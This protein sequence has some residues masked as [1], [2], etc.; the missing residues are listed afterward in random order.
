L[1]RSPSRPFR[2]FSRCIIFF[3]PQPEGDQMPNEKKVIRKLR[4]ILSADVK[5]YSILMADDEAFTIK[6][7]KE[8]RNI[9]T[10]Q[11]E[12]YEGR[13]VDAPGDNLLAEFSSAVDAVECAV[14]IQKRLKRENDQFAE[15]KKL[16]Y[17]IGVNIGD[18]V[19]DG[20]HIYG[21]GVNVAARIE[22]LAEPGGV[23]ISRNTYDHIKDKLNFGYE[24]LG[25]HEVKNIKDPVRVYKVL[26]GPGDAG[27]L[28]GEKSHRYRKKWPGLAVASVAIL[29]GIIA[30]Q[31]YYEKSPP[32][33]AAS[34]ENMAFP[35]PDKPSIAVLPF[36]NISN[37]PKQEYFSDGITE[38][39]ITA[40]SKTPKILVIARNSTFSYKG[41]ATKIKQVA[42]ELGVQYVLEGSVRKEK[43]RV[44]IIAHLIDVLTGHHLWAERYDRNLN[45]IFAL[46]DEI[47]KNI[48]TALRVQLTDGELALFASKGTKYLESYLKLL[49]ARE[50]FYTLTKEGNAKARHLCEEAIAI[51]SE[52]APAY[53]YLGATH[54][55]DITLG[56]SKSPAESLK[57]AFSFI[58]KAKE[59]DESSAEAHS[60]LGWLYVMTRQH[61]EGIAEC[62][63]AIKLAPNSANAHIWM[64]L[65]LKFSGRHEEAVRYSE[66][67]LRL[68]PLPP[69]WYFRAMGAAYSW[70]GRYDEA[71]AFLKKAIQRA[72]DDL[73]T[74]IAL[75]IA[76]IFAGQ[77][78][79]ARAQVAEVIKINPKYSIEQATRSLLFKEKADRERFLN[80]LRKAGLPENP[81]GKE[82]E[83]PSIAVL[84][85]VNM[86]NDPEQEYFS[87]GMTD[88]II[89]DLSKISGLVVI[90]R[91]SAF[92]YKGKNINIPEVA[93]RLGVRYVLEGSVR[94]TS[95]QVRINAQL[96]DAKTDHH[97]WA[98]RFDDTMENIFSL[99]DRVTGQIVS[100]LAVK[101]SPPEQQI[102]TDKGTLNIAAY[103]AYLKGVNHLRK[104]TPGDYVKAI[105]YFKQSIELDPNYSQAYANLAH[106][107]WSSLQGGKNFWDKMG[108]DYVTS[109]V[110]AYHYLELAMKKPTSRGYQLMAKRELFKRNFKKA[111]DYA[112]HAIAIAPNDADALENYGRLL[113][114]TDNPEAG[115]KIFK[116]SI[117]L[118]PLYKSTG[119]IGFAYFSMGDYEQS[120]NYIEKG[121][122]DYPETYGIRSI[123][124]SSYA[125]LGND[126]KA[127]KAFEEFYT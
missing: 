116:R 121:L 17:R 23:C 18:V 38:E 101:L 5:G 31:F 78:E 68:D 100:A 77:I 113:V 37:D 94:K 64:G 8:Y 32:I 57:R 98:D 126:I 74:R 119:Y 48:I 58:R 95:D 115:I 71:F 70:V 26:A 34:V 46:Q 89:T 54:W 11:I 9:M 10:E 19:R 39:I 60:Q 1:S 3:K 52:Y 22:S 62:E 123:L 103:D 27:K 110:F 45:D 61:D 67:A 2:T 122:K 124:A 104:F 4:A 109:R 24:Y 40:L 80:A 79:D 53:V 16:Q 112:K 25:D 50:P 14:K 35:L 97:V 105:K 43:E 84:P 65:A 51:D 76:Y 111:I 66:Q 91:N 7:L 72:P 36:D 21:S 41:K 59:L 42:E 28:L 75:T 120:V 102:V 85:F 107:Y 83:K 30:W 106:I 56:S 99:Q 114:L 93:K 63:Q 20:D 69:Q 73:L 96:I 55:L 125:F 15:D 118:D 12:E 86:S 49:Q 81:P 13:V 44:R 87:D 127:K 88:D 108:I 90:S 117:V 33:E 47:T 92:T 29:I 6:T 82:P